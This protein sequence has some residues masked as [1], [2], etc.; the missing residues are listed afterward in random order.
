MPH[1]ARG[2]PSLGHGR[3][4]AM[5]GRFMQVSGV[6]LAEQARESIRTAILDGTLAPEERI[7]IEELAGELGI[8]RTPIREALKALEGEGLVRLVPHRGAIV[9][10][11]AR[12][13]L[14]HRYSIRA[15]LEGYAAELA[16]T[17]EPAGMA[18][19]LEWICARTQE[20]LETPNLHAVS[21]LV[22]LNMEFHATIREGARSPT[23]ERILDQLR[24]PVGFSMGYWSDAR[25]RRTSYQMH[26]EI[27]AAFRKG[28]P[29]LTKQ[30]TERHLLEARDL[31][32]VQHHERM[33]D[34]VEQAKLAHG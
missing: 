29:A 34:V 15:M 2:V 21:E 13:E 17:A 4:S 6:S 9:A 25:R 8:S 33:Q 26:L 31:L 28:D 3:V 12:D 16:C 18:A 11:F 23:L 30:L 10:R 7:T 32:V 1:A 24:N 22:D 20:L 14:D 27:A 5:S 19:A